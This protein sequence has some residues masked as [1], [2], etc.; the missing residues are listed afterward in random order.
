MGLDTRLLIRTRPTSTQ[1]SD[2]TLGEWRSN[3]SLDEFIHLKLGK[4]TRFNQVIVLDIDDV[5]G[6][7]RAFKVGI[8]N[9][10]DIDPFYKALRWLANEKTKQHA[11]L[12][13]E[14]SR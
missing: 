1:K 5:E 11:V 8:I 10:D 14:T 12:V 3:Y 13:Y 9:T 6:V 4:S 7:L 2:I